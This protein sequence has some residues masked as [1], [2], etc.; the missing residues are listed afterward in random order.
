VFAPCVAIWSGTLADVPA[1][2]TKS[3]CGYRD[4]GNPNTSDNNDTQSKVIGQAMF[5]ELGVDAGQLGPADAGAALEEAVKQHLGSLRPDLQVVR[6][7]PVVSFEQY[8]HLNVFPTFRRGYSTSAERL[9][10]VMGLV[11]RLSNADERMALHAAIDAAQGDLRRQDELVAELV[12]HMPE[13]ALLRVDVTVAEP[14]PAALLP[15]IHVALSAKWSLRTDRAQDCVSQGAKLVAQRRGRMPHFAVVTIEPR[16]AMLKILGDGS[17]SV[18]CVYHLD[19]PALTRAWDRLAAAQKKPHTWSPYRSFR[20]LVQQRRLR[21]YDEL[22]N[23]VLR[24]GPVVAQEGKG[25]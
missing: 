4:S 25:S 2:F 12:S 14:Q 18:D 7:Q 8:A 9:A 21:D 20:R 15:R 13:E 16:P 11:E 1:P 24:I 17:G 10:R 19:L 23:E 6:S 22:V 3:L 5:E